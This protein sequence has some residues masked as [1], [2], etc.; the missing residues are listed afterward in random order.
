MLPVPASPDPLVPQ[1][2]TVPFES[3]A[4]GMRVAR[5]IETQLSVEVPSS[6][7]QAPDMSSPPGQSMICCGV[8]EFELPPLPS[9]PSPL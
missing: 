2:Q 5:A 6:T 7:W 1:H 4:A 3:Q 9:S 8:V